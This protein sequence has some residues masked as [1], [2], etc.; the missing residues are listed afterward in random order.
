MRIWSGLSD[1]AESPVGLTP[2]ELIFRRYIW[3]SIA[4]RL[5]DDTL[6]SGAMLDDEDKQ[7]IWSGQNF[8]R[9]NIIAIRTKYGP[10]KNSTVNL[11]KGDQIIQ[12]CLANGVHD[13]PY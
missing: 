7:E 5:A 9:Q 12:S 11:K 13:C 2:S 1:Q 10:N 8:A 3:C 4:S 6:A